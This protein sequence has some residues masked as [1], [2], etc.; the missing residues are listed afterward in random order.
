MFFDNL[1][2]A[3]GTGLEAYDFGARLHNI[4]IGRWMNVDPL[5]EVSRKWSPYNYCYNNPLKYTDPDGMLATVNESGD[6]HLSGN[7]AQDFIGSLQSFLESEEE[8]FAFQF[9]ATLQ[10]FMNALEAQVCGGG[11]SDYK[12]DIKEKVRDLIKNENF[13][14]AYNAILNFYPNLFTKIIKDKISSISFTDL[15]MHITTSLGETSIITFSK[16]AFNNFKNSDDSWAGLVNS[17][18]HEWVHVIFNH[19]IGIEYKFYPGGPELELLVHYKTNTNKYLPK[20]SDR[21]LNFEIRNVN[22]YYRN[23]YNGYNIN[24]HY[25]PPEKDKAISLSYIIGFFNSLCP[26]IKR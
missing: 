3:D 14:G 7:T 20:L 1:Q 17:I 5:A 16:I 2:V 25:F 8:G 26:Y 13:M 9:I 23:L 10:S 12:I 21:D 6:A 4:Q 22:D 15:N 11:G 24:N 19:G 18:Y